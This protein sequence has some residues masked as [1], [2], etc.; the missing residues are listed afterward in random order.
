[1]LNK[2]K[3]VS[4][5]AADTTVAA[6]TATPD[7]APGTYSLE[8]E[9]LAYA[10]KIASA[11][12]ASV[13]AEIGVGTLTFDFGTIAGGALANGT[14][15][16]SSFTNNGAGSKTVTIGAGNNTLAGIRDAINSAK[17][18]VTATIVND[19]GTTPYRLALTSSQS[20][21]A[22]S[23]KISVSGDA[24]LDSL[25]GYDPAGT[26]NM[27]QNVAAQNSLI[28]LD[29]I[30]ISKPGN[31]I[32]DAISGVTLNLTKPTTAPTSISVTTDS[33]SVTT[34]VNDFVKA[35]NAL[36]KSIKDLTAYNETTKVAAALN[37]E[38][39]VRAIQVS[40]RKVLSSAVD[41]GGTAFT[42][43]SQIGVSVQR[44]STL[45]VDNTKLQKAI[46][47]DFGKIAGLFAAV[48][49][50]SDALISHAGST[51]KTKPGAYAVTV[52]SLASQGSLVGLGGP[53]LN[54]IAGVNDSI[55]VTLD[56]IEGSITLN[57]GSYSAEGL[58]A[59]LQA[60]INGL[61]AFSD[62][63]SKVTASIV[64][65]NLNIISNRYGG[66]SNISF[67]GGNG[68]GSLTGGAGSTN[69][70]GD[71]L[72][73]TINGRAALGVGQYLIGASSGDPANPE[74]SEGLK[75]QVLG[76]V[77]GA[78]GTVNF[79]HGYAQQFDTFASSLLGTEGVLT[80]STDGLGES[81][82]RIAKNIESMQQRYAV[83]EKRIRTQYEGLDSIIGKMQSTQ[84]FLTAQ[85][86]QYN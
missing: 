26:Q 39:S 8:V 13:N 59:E 53:D 81:L 56:N 54:I 45:A 5:V 50:S 10:Q 71:N 23:M 74:P 60:K 43:L 57:A 27:T 1:D 48:G 82:R 41:N 7:A 79:S 22:S 16:G 68:A 55:D 84:S 40:L 2:F 11:G 46:T 78:R 37:G 47:E 64:A 38:A 67:T 4:A 17:I 66:T 25:L 61:K 80:S 30:S 62:V 9:K 18:G 15:T 58:A 3:A 42:T 12:Q 75:L 6:V 83:T 77:L 32:S 31:S 51:A 44:D 86:A 76:G 52:T 72:T 63:G 73:G 19:G 70:A 24:A 14:Y 36:N 20:G 28:K 49:T 33:A 65:G 85:L 34:A 35:Y 69:T 21:A 29:G